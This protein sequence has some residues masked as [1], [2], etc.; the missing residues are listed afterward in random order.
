[1]LNIGLADFYITHHCNLNC[2]Q[3]NRFNNYNF[4]GHLDW[5]PYQDLYQRWAQH[6]QVRLINILGG[7][8][9]MHPDL[10]G[11]MRQL[12]T[13]WPD[14]TMTMMTNGTLLARVPGL[15]HTVQETDCV[16]EICVHNSG[17]HDD[18][19]ER[20]DVFFPGAYDVWSDP[21]DLVFNHMIA[22]DKHGVT[23]KI[24]NSTQQYPSAI[25]L[26]D[27]VLST[28]RSDQQRAHEICSMRSCHHFIDGR[29]YKCGM[30]PLLAAFQQQYRLTLDHD[31][32]VTADDPGGFGIDE[33]LADP[34]ALHHYLGNAIPHCRF[35]PDNL[36][37]KDVQASVGKT[38]IPI[39]LRR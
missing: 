31:D 37:Y 8:P 19:C 28:H 12:R 30:P 33:A 15:Y 23:V 21:D 4:R 14:T 16:V 35:C 22:R 6:S 39:Q 17:W 2:E 20:L 10:Q 9:L 11:W 29:L 34:D 38:T 1:M 25:Q 27:G 18:M 5:R 24:K 7:E 26:R 3:C 13:W 32:Q 36:V